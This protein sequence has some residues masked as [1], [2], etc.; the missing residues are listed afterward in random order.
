M[1]FFAATLFDMDHTQG[2]SKKRKRYAG[3]YQDD[4]GRLFNGVIAPSKVDEHH[5]WCVVCARDVNVSASG[6]YDVKSH[7]KSKLH[8]KIAKSALQHAPMTTFF[9][10][11]ASA[12][13]TE[14]TTAAE[15][16]FCYF[17]EEHNLPAAIAD[18]FCGLVPKMFPDSA[19]A[20]QM[21][22]GRT[23]TT[24][25]VKRCLATEATS[26]VIARCRSGPYSIMIDESTDHNTDKRL[27]VLVRY[28]DTETARSCTRLLDMPVC[29]G[30]RCTQVIICYNIFMYDCNF[31]YPVYTCIYEHFVNLELISAQ[32]VF[33]P[34][35]SPMTTYKLRFNC[36]RCHSV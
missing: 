35:A 32:L 6:V 8:E 1:Q 15:F 27:T 23:K 2:P 14:A 12:P 3:S 13:E 22:C 16:M 31:L 9:K 29:N 24:M 25:I 33:V 19:I 28:F 18:H 26:P 5:A 4:W 7:V 21:R 11:K 30:G 17:V 20:K 10:A 34:T 36:S